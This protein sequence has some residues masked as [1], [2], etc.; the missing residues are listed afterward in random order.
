MALYE[1][2][3]IITYWFVLVEDEHGKRIIA[4]TDNKVLAQ[5]YMDFHKYKGFT[6]KSMRDRVSEIV[7]ITETA[8]INEIH[9]IPILTKNR[10]RK[11]KS[12]PVM[13]SVMVPITTGEHEMLKD[14]S[15]EF[16]NSEIPYSYLNSAIPY[17]KPKWRSV[18]DDILLTDVIKAV[19]HNQRAGAVSKLN[20]DQLMLMTRLP[21]Q[22]F[23]V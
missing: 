19:C 18:M 2:G 6:L 20:V 21:Q 10:N 1:K 22:Y 9:L 16:W 13:V 15:S 17:L 7:K 23:G 3:D 4:H 11:S 14:D 12:D 5:A 8:A